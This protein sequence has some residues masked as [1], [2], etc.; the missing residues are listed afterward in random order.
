MPTQSEPTVLLPECQALEITR[1]TGGTLAS[2]EKQLQ[3]FCALATNFCPPSPL[4]LTDLDNHMRTE[5]TFFACRAVRRLLLGERLHPFI[6]QQSSV[7]GK[8]G[9]HYK[10][11][12]LIMSGDDGFVCGMI[13]T[14]MYLPAVAS[15]ELTDHSA[16]SLTERSIRSVFCGAMLSGTV[17]YPTMFK[18]ICRYLEFWDFEQCVQSFVA[19]LPSYL[20][21]A[22]QKHYFALVELL[23]HLSFSLL[24]Q[25]QPESHFNFLKFNIASFT[26]TWGYHRELAELRLIIARNI[27]KYPNVL[28]NLSKQNKHQEI[29]VSSP[30]LLEY[31]ASLNQLVPRLQVKILRK[32]PG[33]KSHKVVVNTTEGQY[34][35][36]Y[37]TSPAIYRLGMCMSVA[38]ALS[39]SHENLYPGANFLA[40]NERPRLLAAMLERIR[41]APKD[42]RSH[43]Q[44]NIGPFATVTQPCAPSMGQAVM[45]EDMFE[46]TKH[47]SLENFKTTI[48]NTNMVINT[49]ISCDPEAR[50]QPTILNVPRLTNNFVIRKYSVKEPSFTISVF[51]SETLC[52]LTAINI[53]ISGDLLHFFFA[54]GTLK[55]FLPISHIFPVS[56]ANWNSTLDLHG[57]ENQAI[58]RAGRRDVFWT[59]NFPSVV[60]SKEGLNVSWFKAATATVS[61]VYG[62]PLIDQLRGELLPI[63]TNPSARIDIT[64]NRIFSLLEARNRSQIQTLHKRFLECL[65]ECCSF[66]RLD[67]SCIRRAVSSGLFDFSKKI[68]SHTKSKHECALLGYKKCNLVPKIYSKNK[69]SRL[70]ELGRNANFACFVETTGH[71]CASLKPLIVRHAFRRRGLQWRKSRLSLPATLKEKGIRKHNPRST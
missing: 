17:C 26:Y 29:N 19:V 56:V 27:E 49:K 25:P 60:S 22:C 71:N 31:Q 57:L 40:S 64:K 23:T 4:T 46:P 2:P 7:A 37:P 59:T 12:G 42:R 61:K 70:D 16:Q 1:H 45:T 51:F 50:L 39:H 21:S 10:G 67:V 44:G 33:S 30:R 13:T 24:P 34:Y 15:W 63:V 5:P 11:P 20:H 41:Y 35:L 68:I 66:L 36:V 28:K 38:D 32:D 53:N 14:N 3:I 47:L 54:M 18:L 58:V 65:V 6:H 8:P 48:F 52:Q 55:C 9:P 62:K 69:K 43:M